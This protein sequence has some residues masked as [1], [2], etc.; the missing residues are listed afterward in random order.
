MFKFRSSC[1]EDEGRESFGLVEK[2]V[3]SLVKRD[4]GILLRTGLFYLVDRIKRLG[5]FTTTS[6]FAMVDLCFKGTL[7][8]L[9]LLC[10]S[11]SG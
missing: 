4:P 11:F 7:G 8:I 5:R 3:L 10:Q 9:P 6:D 1:I 2:T